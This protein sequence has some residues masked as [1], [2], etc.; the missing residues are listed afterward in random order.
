MLWVSDSYIWP[1]KIKTVLNLEP[2]KGS[3]LQKLVEEPTSY[4][5]SFLS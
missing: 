4:K 1:L 5:Q 2:Y 3:L